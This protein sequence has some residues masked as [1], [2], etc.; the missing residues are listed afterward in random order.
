MMRFFFL[1][2]I[3][4][5]LSLSSSPRSP[6]IPLPRT[7][8]CR[9]PTR[10][11]RRS[12]RGRAGQNA[13]LSHARAA[14]RVHNDGQQ[15]HL[16]RGE[17]HRDRGQGDH[18]THSRAGSK[19]RVIRDAVAEVKAAKPPIRQVQMHLLA[20]PPLRPD[21]EAIAHQQHPD[22][23]FRVDRRPPRMAVEIG[24]V[25]ADAGQVHEP[26]NGPQQVVLWDL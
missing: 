4:R 25:A 1:P 9:S 20:E 2:V 21:A 19:C 8:R 26:I 13:R 3:L 22:E 24:E 14:S 11:R 17:P 10:T 12:R 7:S 15:G 6:S 23:E 18:R 5:K 16:A